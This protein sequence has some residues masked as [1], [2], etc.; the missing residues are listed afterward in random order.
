MQPMQPLQQH[1]IRSCFILLLVL[2]SLT[3]HA[4]TLDFHLNNDAVSLDYTNRLTD[5]ALNLGGGLLH[6]QDNGDAFY[7]SLFVA[8]NINKQSNLLAGV[9]GRLYYI[10]TDSPDIKGATVSLGG[11]IN[12]D[13][14]SITNL[15]LRGEIYYAPDVLSFDDVEKN[16]DLSIRIQY[17]IIEQAWVYLG[18]RNAEVSPV[19][20]DNRTIDEG[21]HVGLMLWF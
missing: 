1:G 5:S 7:G 15:S 4:Q 17:R 6:H 19:H 12:Y 13:I 8:D 16:L 10:N 3:T 2:L 18:Y 21:G 9:G 14:P 20:G 11:F